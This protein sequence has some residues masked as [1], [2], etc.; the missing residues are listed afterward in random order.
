MF[1][2]I[3][4]KLLPTFAEFVEDM[5]KD[6]DKIRE[7]NKEIWHYTCE[8]GHEWESKQSPRGTYCF[9]ESGQTKCPI[10]KSPICAGRV[11]ING[12]YANMGAMHCDFGKDKK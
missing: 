8:N 3:R 1:K 7:K 5:Y 2:W 9:G 4:R 11:Y 6:I 10:C 12:E